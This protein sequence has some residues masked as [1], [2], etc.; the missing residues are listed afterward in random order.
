METF[1]FKVLDMSITASFCVVIV[2]ILRLFLRKAPKI[3]SYLLWSIVAFRLLCPVSLQ[4]SISLFNLPFLTERP[5][6]TQ[7]TF[8]IVSQAEEESPDS[9]DPMSGIPA[10]NT[11][12][13][14]TE[15]VRGTIPPVEQTDPTASSVPSAKPDSAV[16]AADIILRIIAASL[17]QIWLWGIIGFLLY[18]IVSY[19]RLRLRLKNTSKPVV[20]C[21]VG[22]RKF[23][24]WENEKLKTPFI[25]GIFR[26]RIFLPANLTDSQ[27][28]YCLAHESTHIRRYDHLIKLASFVLTSIYW[29]QPMVWL[30]YFLMSKDMEMS[31]DEAVLGRGEL[32]VRK[33]YS[34][35]LL[36]LSSKQFH[37]NAGPLAFG[38]NNVKARIRNIMNYKKPAFW[39]SAVCLLIV[40]VLAAVLITNPK[41]D[42]GIIHNLSDEELAVYTEYLNQPENNGFLLDSFD[43]PEDIYWDALFYDGAGLESKVCS[44][45]E[46][47]AYFD[48]IGEEPDAGIFQCLHHFTADQIADFAE[49]KTGVSYEQMLYKLDWP[50]LQEYDTYHSY[51]KG[52]TL[53]TRVECTAGYQDPENNILVLEYQSTDH[54]LLQGSVTLIP[55]PEEPGHFRFLK[56]VCNQTL[57]RPENLMQESSDA[58]E[59][60]DP[61]ADPVNDSDTT[62]MS[63]Y[64][65]WGQADVPSLRIYSLPQKSSEVIGM[66]SQDEI[67][68]ILAIGYGVYTEGL[69]AEDFQKEEIDS[70]AECQEFVTI[71]IPESS[72]SD[73]IKG[74]VM[75]DALK[76]NIQ[77]NTTETF[78][79][80]IGKLWSSAFCTRD[81][82]TLYQ[83]ASDKDSFRQWDL[84]QNDIDGGVVSFG[85]IPAHGPGDF[86][87]YPFQVQTP[88]Q[89][90]KI[91]PKR[92]QILVFT[93]MHKLPSRLQS[94]GGRNCF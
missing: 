24:V 2:C 72:K 82:S 34:H 26:P 86:T 93:I 35:T 52:D 64:S 46:M 73:A 60:N 67:V 84:V 38:E 87:N 10:G 29:F 16:N 25:M 69:E 79:Y 27:R 39:V 37:V 18:G 19:E 94:C 63:T 89:Q 65:L 81:A 17:P 70:M 12:N 55:D 85:Y 30:A 76:L 92:K 11:D 61:V 4:S 62:H 23:A 50:Y 77:Y 59:S 8:H 3:Y 71:P 48:L 28:S 47:E 7:E 53:Y 5:S 41:Q 78:A 32:D 36:N 49:E 20:S 75:A 40:A 13:S 44:S 54:D 58:K 74:Y 80:W 21:H 15:T 22:N 51:L 31:C 1:F 43:R 14:Y 45:A 9:Y 6:I 57:A 91:L 90:W 88:Y 56:N 68:E 33:E 42:S 83:M 66:L